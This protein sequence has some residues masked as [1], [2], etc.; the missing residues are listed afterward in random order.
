[1][2]FFNSFILCHSP[3]T[4]MFIRLYS[5]LKFS[6]RFSW[7][8]DFSER[9]QVFLCLLLTYC[10]R[11]FQLGERRLWPF[12]VDA[13]DLEP[14]LKHL[15]FW[16]LTDVSGNGRP[17]FVT[18]QQYPLSMWHCTGAYVPSRRQT[19]CAPGRAVN[20]AEKH[21]GVSGYK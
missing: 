11:C 20:L 12:L 13:A 5:I 19:G 18:H 4:D 16:C 9:S 14:G 1:M 2:K 10:L 17:C 3:S 7:N 21:A 15:G 8:L 6:I